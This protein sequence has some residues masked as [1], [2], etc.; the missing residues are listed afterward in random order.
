MS[1][2]RVDWDEAVRLYRSGLST[3]QVAKQL[4]T[5]AGWVSR[6][7]AARDVPARRPA[8]GS[9][10]FPKLAFADRHHNGTRCLEWTGCTNPAGY[11][12]TS[13]ADKKWL[14]HRW[15]YERWVAPIPDGLVIDHLCR[16]PACA[17]PVH[18]EAVTDR[19]NIYR[20]HSPQQWAEKAARSHC[21]YGHEWTL[22][23]THITKNGSRCCRACDRRRGAE[24][25]QRR[26]EQR[27]AA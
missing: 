23:N 15:V 9:H 25:R 16:N 24:K 10:V 5:H 11:G 3:L 20:G 12:I 19:V 17:N 14:V 26:R 22:E 18:L 6:I 27:N 8:P 4:G 1:G 7:L 21:S 13:V 2:H